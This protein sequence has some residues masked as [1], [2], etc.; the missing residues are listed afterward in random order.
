M[1]SGDI[2]NEAYVMVIKIFFS[3][4]FMIF[5]LEFIYTKEM[6]KT[7]NGFNNSYLE[8]KHVMHA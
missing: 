2:L 5:G 1:V 8:E 4:R 6:R 3:Q 7:A